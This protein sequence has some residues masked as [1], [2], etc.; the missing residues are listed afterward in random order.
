MDFSGKQ[1]SGR[2]TGRTCGVFRQRDTLP[3]HR[4]CIEQKQ[5]INQLFTLPCE[6]QQGLQRLHRT[7]NTNHRAKHTFEFAGFLIAVGLG[8]KALVAGAV[9]SRLV[10]HDLPFE[11]DRSSGHQGSSRFD[12]ATVHC[13]T[14]RV[15]VAAVE[16]DIDRIDNLLQ[17]LCFQLITDDFDF[18]VRVERSESL[19]RGINLVFADR[20]CWWIIWRCRLE[21]S[22]IS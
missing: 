12:A 3:L 18:T 21:V 16:H 20:A 19:P 6:Q 7:D 17:L 22:T 2:T 1:A 15:I 4:L 8:V 10:I 11:T 9:R 5:A 13:E 14:G